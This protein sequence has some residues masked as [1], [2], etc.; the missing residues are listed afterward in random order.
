MKYEEPIID[1]MY[2]EQSVALTLTS[3]GEWNGDL[4]DPI[5]GEDI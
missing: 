2:L 3:D 1:L 5:G 4:D